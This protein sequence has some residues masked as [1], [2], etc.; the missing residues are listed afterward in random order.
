M[1]TANDTG[2]DTGEHECK[3]PIVSAAALAGETGGISC[4]TTSV[5]FMFLIIAMSALTILTRKRR[6]RV[7]VNHKGAGYNK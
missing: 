2:T 3:D 4:S 6:E 5:T 7:R 1:D